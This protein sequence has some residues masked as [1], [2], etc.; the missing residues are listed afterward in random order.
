MKVLGFN[1]EIEQKG[2]LNNNISI[3]ITNT[4][5][6]YI[7]L[8]YFYIFKYFFIYIIPIINIIYILYL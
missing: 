3:D 4:N 8:Y 7:N 2:S 6:C 5:F 1:T